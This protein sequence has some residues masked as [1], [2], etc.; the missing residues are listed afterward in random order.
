MRSTKRLPSDH[1]ISVK[2]PAEIWNELA[3]DVIRRGMTVTGIIN[4]L[5]YDRYG[6]RAYPDAHLHTTE[7][8]KEAL[9]RREKGAHKSQENELVALSHSDKKSIARAKELIAA[10]IKSRRNIFLKRNVVLTTDEQRLSMW[11]DYAEHLICM[12]NDW[13]VNSEEGAE[14]LFFHEALGG[15]EGAES[16]GEITKVLHSYIPE[17]LKFRGVSRMDVGFFD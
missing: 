14:T 13:A 5:L 10:A 9:Q 7:W 3:Q 16:P 11:R 6:E 12:W 1:H 2:I 8:Q 4:S 17:F 15:V